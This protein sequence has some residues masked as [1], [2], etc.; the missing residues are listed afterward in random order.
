[1]I[2]GTRVD[3]ERDTETGTQNATLSESGTMETK[4]IHNIYEQQYYNRLLGL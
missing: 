1:M 4:Y 2:Q 3:A